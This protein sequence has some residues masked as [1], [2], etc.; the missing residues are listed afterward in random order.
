MLAGR[1]RWLFVCF[2]VLGVVVLAG[3]VFFGALV[4]AGVSVGGRVVGY[5]LRYAELRAGGGRL[6]I[7]RPEVRQIG[8]E[9]LFAADRIDVRYDLGR[10]FGGPYLYGISDVD[11]VRPR[12]TVVHHRDGSYNVRFPPASPNGTGSLPPLPKIRV[13]IEG[14]ALGLADA[15]RIFAHSRLLQ[16]RDLTLD[17]DVDPQTVSH[18]ALRVALA[19]AGGTFPISGRGTFDER[20]G[21]ED[22]RLVAKSIALGPLIDYALNSTS[23]HVA[24]GVL[25]D[26][27]ARAYGFADARGHMRRHLSAS[28]ALDHFQP[29]LNGLAKPLRDG[30]GTVRAFDGGIAIPKVD[31]S[32]AGVPVR[33]AGAIYDFERPTLRLGIAGAGD[34]RRL[35]TLSDASKA[36]PVAGDVRFALF[37][38]G[39]ATQPTTLARF[40]GDRIT[41]AR[42]PIDAPRGLVVLHGA[43]TSIVRTSFGYDGAVLGARGNVHVEQKRTVVDI[44]ANADAPAQRIPYVATLLGAMPLR[45]SAILA[46]GQDDAVA[47]GSI[48]GDAPGER[49]AGTF[50]LGASGTGIVGPLVLRGPGTRELDLRARFDAP[51]FSGG[52][53]VA[54]ARDFTFSTAGAQ[55]VLPGL[56]LPKP[57]DASGTLDAQVAGA[58]GGGRSVFGG[59]LHARNARVL[60]YPVDD[61]SARAGALDGARV[62]I[63]ARYRGALAPLAR[64]AGGSLSANGSVDVP[65]TVVANGTS[66]VFVQ[67]LDARFTGARIA[68]IA[69]DGFEGS[70]RL[71]GGAIDVYGARA[72]LDGHTA[73]AQGRFGNGGT[74]DVSASGIDV[75][76]LR[77]AGLPVRSGNVA[78]VV[79]LGGSFAAPR[80]SGGVVASGVRLANSALPDLPIDAGTSFDYAGGR[81]DVTDA[82][83]RAGPAVA[84]L[85]GTLA[86]L[87]GSP[88][89]ASYTFAA[90]VRHADV[91]ALARIA[92]VRLPYPEGTLEADVSVT[93]TGA[94]P[95]VAGV[96]AIPQGS[97]NGLAFSDASV[98]LAGDAARIDARDGRA[99]VGTSVLGFDAA[100]ARG[101]Q[102][103]ALRAPRVNLADFDDFFDAGDTLAGVGSIALSASA[104]ADSFATSGRVRFENARYR[105][106]DVGGARA[107]W[108]TRG[109]TI[110]TDVAAGGASGRFTL[111]GTAL[112]A[113]TQPLR[114]PL[115]RT[116][117]ALDARAQNV[118]L[119]TWLPAFGVRLPVGGYADASATMRGAYP[120][121]VAV[122]NASV[123]DG[124][125]GR[126]A[127][128]TATLDARVANG[129]A[130]IARGAFA[131]DNASATL[132][133]TAGITPGA[134]FD[135]T[136]QA[137]TPDIGALETTL[138]GSKHD[139][140]GSLATTTRI[141][142][143][144]ARPTLAATLDGAQLRYGAYTI[145][146]THLEAGLTRDRVRLVA[147][148]VDLQQ[149][150]LLASGNAPLTGTPPLIGPAT[151]PL[152]LALTAD[153]IDL[154]QFAALLPKGTR[155]TGLLDGS[156]TLDG[157]LASPG[158]R[159]TLAL[160]NGAYAGPL[161]RSKIDALAAQ[162][163][164]AGR[165]ATLHDASARIGGGTLSASGTVAV[166]DLREPA[167]TATAQLALLASGAV[168]DLPSLFRGRVDGRVSVSRASRATALV[169][170][171]LALSSARIPPTA[172]LQKASAPSAHATPLPAAL[173]LAVAVGNDVRVQGSGVDIGAK[174]DLTVGGTIAAPT[175]AGE[176]DATGGTISVYRTFTIAYPSTLTFDGAGVVPIVDARATTSVDNPPTDVSLHVTGPSTQ[177]D[178]AFASSPAYSRQQIL[179]LLVGA[180]ALGAVSGIATAPGGQPA[181]NPFQAVAEGQLGSL[182]AQNV[183]EP[184]SS[185]IGSAVGLNNLALGYTPGSGASVGAQKKLFKNVSA[186]FA[187]SFNYP[188]RQSIGLVAR[189]NP[190]SALQL[191]FFSQPQSNRFDT[192]EGVQSLN[193]TN[194]SVTDT[195]PASGSSGFSFSL[196]RKF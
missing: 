114:D 8:S 57:P 67:V 62:A 190:A 36:L 4:R 170:G 180:Q 133:G 27:D 160:A 169:S 111:N 85:D 74:L 44:L 147:A 7:V 116:S 45:A 53:I 71:H 103:V 25:N 128:R 188:Q 179:G 130:T 48:V 158:L 178:I 1:R 156:V 76:R 102:S 120:N 30:R 12:V 31:G 117:V 108:S 28:A 125:A 38:E 55:P 159:G 121:L 149:G 195:E 51:H 191:T 60:G 99:T 5:D 150:R 91:A 3:F 110:R 72:T 189:P 141:T 192:F 56:A 86:G 97:L 122:A 182:L 157:S 81:L 168:V 162:V 119:A 175:I 33:I 90:H 88:Q 22:A 167:A 9:P 34:V 151:A 78:A 136:L 96:I 155:V 154:A 89:R 109:R 124:T 138:T 35:I 79:A 15:T 118:A 186:V 193:S 163:T 174:G 43:D 132:S 95:H 70:A 37:V 39:D 32:I 148:E 137:Q 58:F 105:R 66:D 64:A 131:I 13:T 52:T 139:A 161:E 47:S 20:R 92:R 2:G 54:S 75:A 176:L 142:G 112:V 166:P 171:T 68:G 143:T 115:H 127:I 40:D 93:G 82:V 113:A 146:R 80:V 106:F 144:A 196:Q 83:V 29:Y 17:A 152:D 123:R 107:D 194:A 21:Y 84:R 164:F 24:G 177:L 14:G 153:R 18:V 23:L 11:L 73:V 100:L 134:A 173:D 42:V 94:T 50:S 184:F 165:S 172:L 181:Q 87:R 183:L 46:G 187:E 26:V 59:S 98:T 19:E 65:V 126:V 140:S 185:Q 135:L 16:L 10:V 101:T 77:G 41:Y 61:L 49:L 6:T 63:E 104:E 145:P 129:R 69:L